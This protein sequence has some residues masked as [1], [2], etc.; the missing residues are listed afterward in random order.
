MKKPK[1]AEKEPASTDSSRRSEAEADTSQG[2]EDFEEIEEIV[3]DSDATGDIVKKLR[4]R[5]KECQKEKQEYLD[6]WQRSQ[7][8]SINARKKEETA[9]GEISKFAK[10]DL[11]V[12]ILPVLDSFEMAFGNKTAWEKV[13]SNWRKGIEHIHSQLLSILKENNLTQTNPEG[14]SFNPELHDC[15]ETIETNDK[16]QDGKVVEVLQKGYTFYNKIIR[17]AKVKVGKLTS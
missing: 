4:T 17:P 11:I 10:E 7:A 5:L 12:E 8:D 6:G 13:D 2:G 1:K 15:V 9:R 14:E 16:K 3:E